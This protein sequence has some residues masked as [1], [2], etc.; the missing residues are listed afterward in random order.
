MQRPASAWICKKIKNALSSGYQDLMGHLISTTSP[1]SIL[2]WI[3]WLYLKLLNKVYSFEIE[4]IKFW[5]CGRNCATCVPI[6]CLMFQVLFCFFIKFF[7][8]TLSIYLFYTKMK[9]KSY[10]CPKFIRNYGRKKV[11]GT[12][13][14]LSTIH[15]SHRP[16]EPA[17]YILDWRISICFV[18][19]YVCV[20]DN[21]S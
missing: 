18:C 15:L 20:F 9:I 10:E 2:T 16:S 17:Y 7:A 6:M 4:T 12:S 8:K 5:Q 3:Q 13:N 19:L 11:L 14:A 1:W 21:N